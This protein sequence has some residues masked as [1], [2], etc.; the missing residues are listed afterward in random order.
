MKKEVVMI[1]GTSVLVD[2]SKMESIPED[3][4]DIVNNHFW[5][6]IDSSP[7][8]PEGQATEGRE[9]GQPLLADAPSEIRQ[10]ILNCLQQSQD[11]LIS[12]SEEDSNAH[13]QARIIGE[14]IYKL[15]SGVYVLKVKEEE[16]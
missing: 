4:A 14:I 5:E 16:E 2:T 9:A 1:N 12:V 15:C 7:S 6:L 13:E 8:C 11:R 10:E 3:I